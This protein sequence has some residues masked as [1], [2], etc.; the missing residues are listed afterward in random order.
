MLGVKPVK[1]SLEYLHRELKARNIHPS[2]Q[3]LKVLEY[4][5]QNQI[6]PTAD[7]IFTGLQKELSTLSKTTVYNTLRVLAEA[8]LVRP[9]S[10]D[11]NEARYD[12]LTQDHGHFQCAAC[13]AVYNFEIDPAALT[14][15]E[16][17]HFQIYDRNVYFKGLCPRCLANKNE[18]GS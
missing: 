18:P 7:Q 2:H 1:P 17:D 11:G 6:H 8:G 14:S 16:L 10:I 9:I 4:L 13:G 5:V 12:I 3:R 15:K